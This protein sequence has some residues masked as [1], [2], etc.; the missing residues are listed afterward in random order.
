VQFVLQE[1][2]R[3]RVAERLGNRDQAVASYARVAATWV[4]ADSA[5]QPLVTEARTA[6]TRLGGDRSKAVRF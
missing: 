6:L 3:A 1:L 2:Q 4:A 5:L